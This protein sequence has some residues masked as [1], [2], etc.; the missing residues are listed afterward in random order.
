MGH[1]AKT[2]PWLQTSRYR[3]ARRQGPG[4]VTIVPFYPLRHTAAGQPTTSKTASRAPWRQGHLVFTTLQHKKVYT[5]VCAW[6]LGERV[7]ASAQPAK[8][9]NYSSYAAMPPGGSQLVSL[10]HGKPRAHA[11]AHT[12]KSHTHAQTHTH[13]YMHTHAHIHAHTHEKE[14][15]AQAKHRQARSR[16]AGIHRGDLGQTA[17]TSAV[18]RT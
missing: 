9:R 14:P 12:H 10:L 15:C 18:P 7:R 5:W 17:H 2:T 16:Q 6:A 1:E 8:C 4:L 11:H 13:T 3:E